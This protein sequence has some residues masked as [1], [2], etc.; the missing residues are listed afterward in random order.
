VLRRSIVEGMSRCWE[1]GGGC[2]ICVVL[3]RLVI[4]DLV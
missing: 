4:V 2:N 3:E 1:M